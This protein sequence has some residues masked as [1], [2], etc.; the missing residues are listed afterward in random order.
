MGST[1]DWLPSRRSVDS[2]R[3]G[4]SMVLDGH[5]LSGRVNGV[6]FLYFFHGSLSI[7]MFAVV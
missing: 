5:A 1:S 2:H 7:G 4:L 3:G 6:N